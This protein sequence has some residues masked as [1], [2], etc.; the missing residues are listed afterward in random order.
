SPTY[1]WLFL[2]Q[3]TAEEAFRLLREFGISVGMPHAKHIGGKLWELRPGANRF[4]Y[5]AYI[6]RRFVILHAYR[7]QS[8]KTPPQELALAERR[9]AE[10]L[11]G[12]VEDG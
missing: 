9:L 5:F 11:E 8:Q 10:V 7:K 4:F 6:G 1:E 3:A 12:G 2:G